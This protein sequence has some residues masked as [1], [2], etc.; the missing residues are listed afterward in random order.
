MSGMGY[1]TFRSACKKECLVTYTEYRKRK[2]YME[3][4]PNME[5]RYVG[6]IKCDNSLMNRDVIQ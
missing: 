1:V 5:Y 2:L 4:A 3:Y 6:E